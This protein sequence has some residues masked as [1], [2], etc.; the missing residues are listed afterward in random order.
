M[1]QELMPTAGIPIF[2]LLVSLLLHRRPVQ[3][4]WV[5][6]ELE[7]NQYPHCEIGTLLF[8]T[9]AAVV[10]GSKPFTSNVLNYFLLSHLES[11]ITQL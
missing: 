2:R 8:S 7:V 3:V 4:G 11:Q 10:S 9:K 5:A 1:A 6:S